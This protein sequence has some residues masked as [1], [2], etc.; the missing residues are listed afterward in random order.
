MR[1]LFYDA[2]A[3]LWNE[4][5][6]LG[7]GRLGAMVHGGAL[8]E[9]LDLNEDTL[10]SGSPAKAEPLHDLE[11][12]AQIREWIAA[13]E[14]TR[15]EEATR[16][17][18]HNM[19]TQIYMPYGRLSLQLLAADA[20]VTQYRRELDLETGVSTVRFCLN[21]VPVERNVFI[22]LADDVLVIHQQSELPLELKFSQAV[23]LEHSS[24]TC[25]GRLEILGRCPTYAR[26]PDEIRYEDGES[27]HFASLLGVHAQ[28]NPAYSGGGS[29]MTGKVNEVTAIFS[30]CTSF[31]DFQTPPRSQG[32][33]YRNACRELLQKA[34]TLGYRQ[35]LERHIAAYRS[36]FDRVSLTLEGDDY[37]H[38]PT[39]QR[40]RAAAAGTRDNQLTQLLFDYGRY[41]TIAG[42]QPGTQPM[43]LQGIWNDRLIPPWHSN[44]TININTEMNYWPAERCALSQCHEP[45][46]RMVKELRSRGNVFGF[47]GWCAWHN[48]DLWRF[49]HEATNKPLCGYWP[50]GGFWLCRHIWEHYLH[51]RDQ[52]FL[53]EYYP[54]LE[55]AA[56]FLE[57]WLLEKDGCLTTSPS[58]SPENEFLDGEKP[59]AVCEG[60]AM[61]MQ[62]IQDLFD[63]LIQAG[64]ILSRDTAHYAE[65]LCKLKPTLVGED[66]RILEWG[67]PLPEKEPG[68]RHISHLY[69]FHPADVLTGDFWVAAVKKTLDTRMENGG[70][71][72]G[73]SNAWIANIYARLGDGEGVARHIRNM[74]ARSIYPNLLD[75][76]PPFQIDGNFG[77]CAAVCEA[78]FQDHTGE[79]QFLPALP[80]EWRAGSVRGFV[81]RTGQ[82]V[83]F[84]WEA[85]KLTEWEICD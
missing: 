70:G 56:W 75:A 46:L 35:L 74:Y 45:L 18:M 80:E 81:T 27:V 61:D 36:Q 47:R 66:G 12:L 38:I 50:M 11:K 52:A 68:H 33:E 23:E 51:T 43:N 58:T 63:K 65:I 62:I 60:S 21:G 76:H 6:P 32:K 53:E 59:V 44:Y 8:C 29:I 84:R 2:P 79:F 64:K 10:W 49:H 69:G 54:V 71:H 9:W 82:R 26:Q 31:A 13:G 25:Q 72:T 85:G 1:K 14:Y 42:S 78:L 77:I 55:E 17:A 3:A 28:P 5:L 73:W 37:S 41:L 57:D 48:T 34:E 4:A 24:R 40:I 20:Q 22:S 15:A 16:E 19:R 39:D 30:L 83:N 7:N 67:T